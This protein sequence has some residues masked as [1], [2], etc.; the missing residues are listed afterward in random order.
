MIASAEHTAE[1]AAGHA[2]SGT[3]G[4]FQKLMADI[5]DVLA[6][7]SHVKDPNVARIRNAVQDALVSARDVFMD[8]AATIKRRGRQAAVNTDAFV[9]GSPWQAV[10]IAALV[11]A[12]VGYLAG[13]KG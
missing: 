10:G 5:E 6:R 3:P 1:Q 13:R 12:A 11:G 2:N 4:E 7:A 8:S 9:H